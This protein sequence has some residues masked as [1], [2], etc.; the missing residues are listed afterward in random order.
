MAE[1]G[2]CN[3]FTRAPDVYLVDDTLHILNR[4]EGRIVTH[5]TYPAEVIEQMA[6]RAKGI[7]AA[8]G[9][10]GRLAGVMRKKGQKKPRKR[11]K[12]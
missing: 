5:D 9:M 1:S 11:D 2:R 12:H 6:R 8:A 4:V 10:I 7:S 3:H